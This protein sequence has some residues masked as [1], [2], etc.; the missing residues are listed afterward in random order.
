[1]I[2]DLIHK[3][4][5]LTSW[6]L[7]MLWFSFLSLS[8]LSVTD[9]FFNAVP[10]QISA[11]SF[12]RPSPPLVKL[13]FTTGLQCDVVSN[14]AVGG[15]GGGGGGAADVFNSPVSTFI[16]IS[17]QSIWFCSD[18]FI[19]SN[20]FL[21]SRRSLS[22]L[23][24][25]GM[26]FRYLVSFITRTHIRKPTK[27][28]KRCK[29]YFFLHRKIILLQFLLFNKKKRICKGPQISGEPSL[30]SIK[31]LMPHAADKRFWSNEFCAIGSFS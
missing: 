13:W 20:R 14:R 22:V 30:L 25:N 7:P 6:L 15:G 17:S 2:H 4:F 29:D 12:E 18:Y 8:F 21:L 19:V 31:R 11:K 27:P 16:L 10:L 28:M 3:L 5:P 1:M 26:E 9:I 24:K 23:S